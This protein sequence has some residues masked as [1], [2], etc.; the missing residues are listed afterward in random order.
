MS[1]SVNLRSLMD[2]YKLTGPNFLDWLRN[3]RIVLRSEELGYVLDVLLPDP[4]AVDA[5]DE[6]QKAYRKHLKDSDMATCIMLASMSP[7]LQKQHESMDAN[8]IVFHLGELFDEQARSERFET[9][10]LLFTTKMTPGSSAVQYAL[11]MNGYIER[12]TVLGFVMDY[13]LSVELILVGFSDSYSQF[14]LNYRM[15]QISMTIPELINLLKTAEQ[16]IKK[17]S[18][19]VLVVDSSSS[20]SKKK[21]LK[22]KRSKKSKGSA[23]KK[24]TKETAPKGTCFHCGKT[25]HWKRNCKVYLEEL[26]QKKASDASASS[27]KMTKLPFKGKGER[28][29]GVLDLIH[30]DVCGPMSIHARSGCLYFNTFIDDYS[31]YGYLYLMRYKSEA[32]EKFKQFRNEIENQLGKSIKILRSDRGGEYLDQQ[33]LDYLRDNGIL[34][35]W[36]PPYTPQHNGVAERR[37]RTLLDMVRSMMGFAKLPKS[38][39]GYALETVVY[40]L[41]RVPSK[42]V[43]VTPYEIWT[44]KRPYLTHLKVWGCP[45]YVKRIQSD[46]LDVKSNKCLFVGYPK[47]TMGYQFY[48]AKEQ[49]V[50]VLKHAVFLEKEFLL[51]EDSGSKIELEEVQDARTDADQLPEPETVTHTDEVTVQPSTTHEIRRSRRI[52]SVPERYGFLMNEHNDVLLIECDEPTTYEEVLKSSE[53]EK[54]LHAMKSEMDSMYENQVWTLVEEPEGIK[55]IGCKWVFKKKTDMDGN[56]ITYKARL[57]AEDFR[58]R[59]GIDYDETFIDAILN[60]L[61][62]S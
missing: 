33:F 18:K 21:K 1:S 34:S 14:V 22:K 11:K 15:N 54:W 51:Q 42:T 57:V 41:N 61:G 40:L 4:P 3:L 35:Q 59:Q 46:K 60:P 25:G 37:N 45:A 9:S 16:S 7:E 27:S 44:N 32:F 23:A 29:T 43:D 55:P 24:K 19:P 6:D 28:A 58:Q 62:Y 56:V 47:E 10:R 26:K 13:E 36:T 52:R 39:W 49:K 12:L 53:S 50:F 48:L 38:F 17:D 20:G 8:T 2:S 31:R 5:S 30:S